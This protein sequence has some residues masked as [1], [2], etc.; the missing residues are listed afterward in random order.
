MSVRGLIVLISQGAFYLLFG[1]LL[2]LALGLGVGYAIDQTFP[3][4]WGT[5]TENRCEPK[6]RGGCTSIGTWVSDDRQITRTEV[7]LDGVP[8]P[9]GTVRAGYRPQGILSAEQNVVH[10]DFWI[11]AGPIVCVAIA[12]FIGFQIVQQGSRWGHIRMRPRPRRHRAT[13]TTGASAT[14]PGAD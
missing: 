6:P 14:I 3:V 9:D 5:F 13:A 2:L 12:A 11:D 8:G 10:I 7:Q 1:L 4:V